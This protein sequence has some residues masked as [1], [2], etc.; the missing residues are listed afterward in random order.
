MWGYIRGGDV[1]EWG[2]MSMGD[3]YVGVMC[4]GVDMA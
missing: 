1:C 2:G 3:M 4:V